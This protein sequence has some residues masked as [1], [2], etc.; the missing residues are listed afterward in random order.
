M[1]K[2]MNITKAREAMMKLPEMFGG[3]SHVEAIEVTRWGKGVA[4]IIPWEDYEG[5]AETKEIIADRSTLRGI[6]RGLREANAGRLHSAKAVRKKLG[7]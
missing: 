4:A 2:T 5:F 1:T 6:A 7:L 3:K